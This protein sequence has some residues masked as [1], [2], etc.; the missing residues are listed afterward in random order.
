MNSTGTLTFVTTPWSVTLGVVIVLVTLVLAVMGYRRAINKKG[1]IGFLEVMRVLIA[2]CIAITLNQPEWRELYKPEHKPVLAVLH[3]QSKSMRTED[4]LDP[5]NASA[6]PKARA[7]AVSRLTQPELWQPLKERLDVVFEPF[8]S[9]LSPADEATDINQALTKVVEEQK[10]LRAVVLATD[11]DWNTGKPPSEAATQLRMRSVPVLAIPAGAETK[12]PDVQVVSFDVPTFGVEGKPLRVP[13]VIESSLPREQFVTVEMTTGK[14]ERLTKEVTLPPMGRVQDAIVWKPGS[15]GDATLT[16]TLPKVEGERFPDNNTMQ[17][18]VSIRK[19]ELKVLII[20]GLPRW[21]YRYM[22]NAMER[23]P[24]VDVNT[25]LFHP[26]LNKIGQGRGYLDAF[27][28]QEDL[29]KYDVVFIGDVGIAPG[30]LTADQVAQ[31]KKLVRDQASG[32][33]FLP[34]FQGHQIQL[35]TEPSPLSELYPVVL[36]TAQTKGWGSAAPGRFALTESGQRSLLTRLEDTDEASARVW[37]SL[38]GFQWYA[39]ALRAKAGSEILA[40]HS[41][42]SGRYGRIPLLVSRTFG[43]GKILFMGSDGAW[44]WRRGVEDK[45]HY[46][47]WGQVVRWMAY[48]RNMAAGGNLRLFYS[49]DRPRTGDVLT[50]NANALSTTGEP[51][52]DAVVTAQIV[53]PSG[54]AS[55]VRLLPAGEES[56]GLFTSTF[57]PTEPGEH[58]VRLTCPDS[59]APLDATLSIQGSTREKLGQPARHDVLRE[60]ATLTRGQVMNLLDPVALVNAIGALPEPEPEERRVLIWGHPAWAGL[61]LLLM[62]VFW[63]GRKMAGAF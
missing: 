1:A 34:G 55:S 49:P 14:G 19:E 48:Q 4:V 54:K 35:A 58:K 45:Y 6:P 27:P 2:V 37:A 31:I 38:P 3:D 10:H 12:L 53:A 40:T 33:V 61:M 30:M 15:I 17:A 52:R 32:L 47:F 62:A 36:D 59:G 60:I 28:K 44:R 51:L 8:S 7:A 26:G 29:S 5:D 63:I 9:T 22:R 56:Y 23:D 41:S 42:E 13:F 16:L 25:L 20:E 43:A 18:P 21:E 11:G 57:T 24:G 50:L 46:R 39:P